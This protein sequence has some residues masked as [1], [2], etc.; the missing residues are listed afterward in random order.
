MLAWQPK[1]GK[2]P[3]EGTKSQ[4]EFT[5]TDFGHGE[6]T[7]APVKALLLQ[8]PRLV[9]ALLTVHKGGVTYPGV[10]TQTE[11]A[12]QKHCTVQ[13]GSTENVNQRKGWDCLL[14]PVSHD[15]TV[16]GW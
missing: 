3:E 7:L 2:K 13:K 11:H 12:R 4:E 16:V 1:D 15:D 5:G 8:Q 10:R 6:F 14:V 9:H